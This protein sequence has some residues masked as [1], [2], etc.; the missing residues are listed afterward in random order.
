MKNNKLSFFYITTSVLLFLTLFAGGVYGV[1][2]SVGLNF[3]RSNISNISGGVVGDASNV[4]YG[5]AINF[6]P[7][8]TGVIVLSIVLVI[9]SIFDFV[10]L[11]KQIIFFRQFKVVKNS[12]LE[13]KIES[14]VK[15]K[16][17]VLIFVCIIDVLSIL[18]GV[19][20]FFINLRSMSGGG[21]SWVLYLVDILVSLLALLSL[22]L[23]L[24][25]V[26]QI[27]K[28]KKE[29][30][31]KDNRQQKCENEKVKKVIAFDD[32]DIDEIEYVLLKLKHLK[33]SKI[34]TDEEYKL[35]RQQMIG[36][37]GRKVECVKEEMILE[38]KNKACD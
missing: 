10:G 13:K 33:S 12:C 38:N 31:S 19:V 11:I 25:K 34:I 4:S 7:S 22:I 5:G 32:F 36:V 14:K 15:S 30:G 21:V 8:M 2:V 37:D 28:L 6:S 35:I 29:N 3:M 17:S 26:K 1:Y 23:L 27:K 9:L 16:S 20:G 18:A 24:V